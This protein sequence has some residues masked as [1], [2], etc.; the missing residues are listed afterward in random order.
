MKC[1][2]GRTR[3]GLHAWAL[4]TTS[5]KISVLG[6]LTVELLRRVLDC[7]RMQEK[8]G[9]CTMEIIPPCNIRVS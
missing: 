1:D 5:A 9:H 6:E 8:S 7:P 3:K 2:G 4:L